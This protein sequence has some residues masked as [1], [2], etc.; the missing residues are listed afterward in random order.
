MWAV[1]AGG[2]LLGVPIGMRVR[3]HVTRRWQDSVA[4]LIEQAVDL[5]AERD[6]ALNHHDEIASA[7]RNERDHWRALAIDLWKGHPLH[8]AWHAI[9]DIQ[10]KEKAE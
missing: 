1:L 8:D 10:T 6:V 3:V 5:A 2:L 9:N 7:L 4:D